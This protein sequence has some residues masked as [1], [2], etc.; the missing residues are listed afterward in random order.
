MRQLRSPSRWTWVV[1][2]VATAFIVAC[3]N[4]LD[5][6]N[7]QGIWGFVTLSAQKSGTG[8]HFANAEGIFFSGNLSAVPNADFT[9]ADTCSDGVF[10]EGNNLVGVTYLDAGPNVSATIGGVG[11]TLDRITTAN[12]IA[13]RPASPPAYNPGDSIVVELTGVP[14][15]FPGGS[16]RAKTAEAFSFPTDIPVPAGTEAIPLTW[17]PPQTPRSAMVVSLRYATTVT[18]STL[19]RHVLCTFIDDGEASIPFASHS[20]WSSSSGV[21]AVVAT[22]LRTNYVAAGE[23][24]LGVISTYQ[25]PTPPRP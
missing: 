20:N 12:G 13:Y 11:A 24:N 17:T 8:A 18:P 14:G 9:V 21:R 23:G 4:S 10:S 6:I 3:D 2:V 16:I 5:A 1:P 19:S 15:G 25:V 22:R 7:Q